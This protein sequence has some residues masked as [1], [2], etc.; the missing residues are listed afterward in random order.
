MPFQEI[1]ELYGLGFAIHYLRPN[2]KIPLKTG[3][4]KGPRQDLLSLKKEYDKNLNLGVR[5]GEASFLN[6]S[7]LAV[8]DVDIKSTE[9]RHK[10]E[11]LE[12]LFNLFPEV[13]NAPFVLS[14][15]GNGSAHYYVRLKK[16]VKGNERKGQSKELVKV[17][18]PSVGPSKREFFE[19]MPDEIKKGFRL[20]PAWEISVLSE[21]RQVVLPGSIHPDTKRHYVWGKKIEAKGQNIPLLQLETGKS[22]VLN[23]NQGGSLKSDTTPQNK[24][25]W[26]TVDINSLG[27]KDEQLAQIKTGLGVND[28][29]ATCFSLCMA[30]LQRGVSDSKIVSV[31]T[32]KKYF[33]GSTAFD[34]AKT[35]D[36][37]RA[38]Y[39]LEKYCLKKAKEKVNTIAFEGE[40]KELSEGLK[41]R[42]P[43]QN[44]LDLQKG[45]AGSPPILR[46]TLKNVLLIL[47]NEVGK[48]FLK[49]DLFAHDDF[50]AC[51]TPWGCHEG[52]KRS[53]GQEDA[54]KVKTWLIN[55][56]EVECP[57]QVIEEA[58]TRVTLNNTFHPV[59]DFLES[60]EWDGVFRI[61][62]AFETYL[63]SEMER[64]Y[65]RAV[66]RKFFLALIARIY[67]P[68]IK[69]DHVPVLEGFQGVGKSS[70][71]RILVGEKWFM[72]GLP[73]LADKDAALNLQGIWLCEMAELSS[74]YRSQLEATKAFI[75]R[76]T[77]KIRPPYGHRRVDF[78]RSNVF[79]GTTNSKDY[80]SDPTGNR[81][82]WPVE[83]SFCDF[84][85]LEADRLQLLAEAKFMYDFFNEPLYLKGKAKIQAEL[86]QSLRK[87]EDEG[88]DMREKFLAW[89]NLKPEDRQLDV[90]FIK[91]EDLFENGPF[92]K[93][94]QTRGARLDAAR[95]LRDEGFVRVHTKFGKRWTKLK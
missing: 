38:A 76:Q 59:K 91:L 75:T 85:K 84:K 32:D 87:V 11:A 63:G 3:W 88:D 54:L 49:R 42:E 4:T 30:M 83:V 81:R 47:E 66:S 9:S 45:P 29:S 24:R 26:E 20:R 7:F 58:L 74:I 48:D 93:Y 10:K 65:I 6:D 12:K 60:L 1:K 64:E 69:F 41:K 23:E 94:N 37:N 35:T 95:V 73:D 71:G 36:R 62:R 25:I 67:E 28:R 82:Y 18:M 78:P 8:L 92:S 33:L 39:W 14:G 89:L 55:L 17:L 16:P 46:P 34:H 80:L 56:Y 53:A 21:G 43:W 52:Q 70:F 86:I 40:I 51:D 72:D 90:E 68:G 31:L 5:L 15:R 27:L 77:D 44:K 13:K 2:S 57:I 19:L 79:L 61:D 50:F 22:A